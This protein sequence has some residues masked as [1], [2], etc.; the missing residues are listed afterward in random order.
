MV[1]DIGFVPLHPFLVEGWIARSNKNQGHGIQELPGSKTS[2][3]FV[4]EEGSESLILGYVYA[5]PS[6]S[7]EN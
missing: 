4:W 7:R 3:L 2:R 1:Y 6:F 5:Q